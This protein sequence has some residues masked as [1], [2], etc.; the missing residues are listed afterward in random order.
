MA[1]AAEVIKRATLLGD[2][3]NGSPEHIPDVIPELLMMLEDENRPTVLAA[4]L[5]AL[6]HA[7]IERASL[8]AVPFAS[9]EKASVRLAAVVL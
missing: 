3:V 2:K 7:W 9:H 8:S 4:V 6:G 1:S 5:H